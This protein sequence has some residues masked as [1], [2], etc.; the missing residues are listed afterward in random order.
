MFW[1]KDNY[2]HI[3]EAAQL[4][5]INGTTHFQ[6]R[7]AIDN[8]KWNDKQIN[9]IHKQIEMAQ[10]DFDSKNYKVMGIF[11]KFNPNLTKKHNFDKCRATMLTS[12]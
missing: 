1:I 6:F 2:K 9:E 11:H 12:T 4:G 5:S 10:K 8:Y 7:P 3:Y